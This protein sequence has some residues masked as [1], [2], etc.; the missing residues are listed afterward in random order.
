[1]AVL[2][3]DI[4]TARKEGRVKSYLMGTDII[5]KG[6]L[7]AVNEAG[8]VVA[9]PVAASAVGLRF[10]G[11]AYE[12]VDDSAGAGTKWV[13]VY[14]K[15]IFQ[16]VASSITQVM[17]GEMMYLVDDQTIDDVPGT[18][19]I[20]VGILVEYVS[21]TSGWIDIEP[22]VDVQRNPKGSLDFITKTD[23]YTVLVTD[24]GAKFAIAT[25]AKTFTLPST[26]RGLVYQ[27]WNTGATDGANIITISPAAADM[28]SG[29]GLGL[30]VNN[31]DLINTKA[32]AK[33]YDMVEIVGDGADGWIVTEIIGTWAKEA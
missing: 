25:D 27:F 16:F 7:V 26:A 31:K 21:A 5:Y 30:G 13:K 33:K 8:K 14:T 23:D 6:S 15:G 24:S 22:A 17:V 29:G 11:V 10:A 9:F 3:A 12:K 32:T 20:P 2:T 19:G 1:M 4:E 18:Y 28:I